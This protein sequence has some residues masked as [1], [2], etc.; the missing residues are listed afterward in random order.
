MQWRPI[1]FARRILYG[2]QNRFA[3][4]SGEILISVALI[5]A[6]LICYW[7]VGGFEFTNWDDH[8]YVT[9]NP[10][11]HEGLSAQGLKWAFTTSELGNWHPVT[12]MSH[13]LDAQ[14]LGPEN[15]G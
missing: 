9:R 8:R 15:S 11:V 2:M 3:H 1:G 5:A 7:P 13:M 6:I 14:L 4:R 10:V 12:W